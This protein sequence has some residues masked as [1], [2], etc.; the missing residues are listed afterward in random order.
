MAL[1]SLAEPGPDPALLARLSGATGVPKAV[2]RRADFFVFFAQSVYPLL[3]GHRS[4]LEGLYKPDAGRPAAEPVRM[5]AITILQYAERLPDRQAAEAMQYDQRWRLALHMRKS[6]CACDPSLFSV[7]RSRLAGAKQERLAFDAAMELLISEGWVRK[8]SKQRIDSTHVCGLLA[9][10]SR[11]ER[12]RETIRL[13]LIAVD[14]EG[15]FPPEWESMWERYVDSKVDPRASAGKLK[16][17]SLQAARDMDRILAW[18][19]EQGGKWIEAEPMKLL[20]RVLEENYELDENGE[21]KQRRAQPS[22]AVHNPHEPQAQWSTKS[23]TK[24]KEWVGYK[25]QVA[26][27]VEDLPRERGEPTANFITSIVTQEAIASDKAGMTETLAGQSALGLEAPSVLYADGAYI[28]A[29]ELKNTHEQGR[30]LMGPA[31]ASPDRGKVFTAEAFD[32]DLAARTAV[33]PA[34]TPSTQ[35][36]RLEEAITG[37]VSHR[38][39]WNNKI[40]GACPR[41]SECVSP[42]Q[43][44]R[45]LVV[46]EH[47]DFL[48]AR[49]KEMNTEAF[50]KEMH[51]RNGIEGT[52]SELIRAYGLRKARYRGL[53][54]VRLQNHMIGAACNFVRL[55]RRLAWERTRNSNNPAVPG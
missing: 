47:H 37:K 35:C 2:Q 29:L 41:R 53:A 31:T 50:K 26:E 30:K 28:S 14:E 36:S 7:F 42:S 32:V 10:M 21:R 11:L 52:Q 43:R 18:A 5:L 27:T 8:R 45:T 17:Q 55:Y 12:A 19:G 54:K 51:R 6:D 4:K 25:V 39:E 44:H 34:G 20:A 9:R 40:C 13:T 33:C 24:D 22:G 15:A 3:E 1:P 23:T 16:A 49:R 38:F 46:G 48:Q